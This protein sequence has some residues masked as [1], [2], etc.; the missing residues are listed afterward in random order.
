MPGKQEKGNAPVTQELIDLINFCN[1]EKLGLII[2]SDCNSH[3]VAW[4]NDFND[5]RGISIVE[6]IL[7]LN[8]N[9]LNEGNMPTFD[10]YHNDSQ[11]C[12]DITLCNN[13]TSH[14]IQNR[15]VNPND[16]KS[17]HKALD[18]ELNFYNESNPPT[19]NRKKTNWIKYNEILKENLSAPETIKNVSELEN[20]ALILCES[21][22]KAF[23]E[24][25]K[26]S[27][28]KFARRQPWMSNK[29]LQLRESTRRLY[30]KL[31]NTKQESCRFA[32]KQKLKEYKK[33]C[34]AARSNHWKSFTSELDSIKDTARLQ[35]FFEGDN[36]NKISTIKKTDG[37]YT[38]NHEETLEEL[39]RFHFPE[40]QIIDKDKEFI[41]CN[42]LLIHLNEQDIKD[43]EDCVTTEKI[44]WAID[45][46][47]PFKSPGGDNI[48][49]AL[50]QKGIST[51]V[52]HLRNL[53][54]ASLT[55][56]HIPKAWRQVL[57]AFITKASK[58]KNDIASSFRPISLMSF[59]LKT[60]EK[61]VDKR[62]RNIDLTSRKIDIQQHAYQPGKSVDSALHDL[63]TFIEK[64]TKNNRVNLTTF[65][66]LSGAFDNIRH[67]FIAKQAED[68][69]LAPWI[70]NW[71]LATL[72]Q[73]EERS[74]TRQLRFAFVIHSRGG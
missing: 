40:C 49:P 30:R 29:I 8:L 37:T 7:D 70:I 10:P 28:R 59:I 65:I 38:R 39:L 20:H 57:V 15:K 31:S 4:G 52:P 14:L 53:F 21:I 68:K 32:Y 19:R 60:L 50:L 11:T 2:G 55:L 13:K 56:G 12:I 48:F 61:L 33:A 44:I 62:I 23:T 35:K 3:H 73:R 58:N 66:D 69:G 46:F 63:V 34:D 67:D 43:L 64:A 25:S 22:H 24:S 74:C 41:D 18:F 9:L 6:T 27:K 1:V 5:A 51:L 45:S 16:S 26:V 36:A 72:E 54:I 17:D 47:N 42:H 71:L